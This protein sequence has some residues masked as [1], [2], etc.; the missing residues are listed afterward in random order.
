MA[1]LHQR[2]VWQLCRLRMVIRALDAD[3]AD[4]GHCRTP[5]TTS[6]MKGENS[7]N[8]SDVNNPRRSLGDLR[9]NKKTKPRSPDLV[10]KL[11]LQRPT[12]RTLAEQMEESDGDDVVCR[13]AGWF[14]GSGDKKFISVELS[15]LYEA[16]RRARNESRDICTMGQ[17]IRQP[18]NTPHK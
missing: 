5:T 12:L 7:M 14:H 11:K 1:W 13:L 10:G 15:T 3:A 6:S 16:G 8:T 2:T 17:L 18:R 4:A 9:E